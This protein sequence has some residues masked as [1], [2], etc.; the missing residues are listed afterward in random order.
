MVTRREPYKARSRVP[1]LPDLEPT[2]NEAL[3]SAN[4]TM[5]SPVC[6]IQLPLSACPAHVVVAFGGETAFGYRRGGSVVSLGT[7][8]AGVQMWSLA[9][10]GLD[11]DHG[12]KRPENFPAWQEQRLS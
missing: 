1:S 11:Q 4:R 12:T 3:S 8:E 2:N 10:R 5:N 9:P 7:A 6:H